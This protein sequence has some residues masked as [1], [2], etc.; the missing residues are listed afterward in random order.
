VGLP[1]L[2]LSSSVKLSL[3]RLLGV[4]EC[5]VDLDAVLDSFVFKRTHAPMC[6]LR[7]ARSSLWHRAVEDYGVVYLGSAIFKIARLTF[8]ALFF[9]HLFA[10]IF[11]RV[12][13]TSAESPEDV[14]AFYTAKNVDAKVSAAC[15]S[16]GGMLLVT[17]SFH[18]QTESC[19]KQTGFRQIRVD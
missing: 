1:L 12:K 7:A 14:A 8:I 10:C 17:L 6:S 3:P 9:V 15:W 13:E 16:L 18:F 5:D 11:Y 2:C 19:L 4:F